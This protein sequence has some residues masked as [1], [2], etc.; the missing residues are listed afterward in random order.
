MRRLLA[1]SAVIIAVSLCYFFVSGQNSLSA[2]PAPRGDGPQVGSL[3]PDFTLTTMK[4]KSVSLAQ[5]RGKVV[6]LNFWASWCP[7]CRAEM[8]SIEKL[9]RR[10]KKKGNFV[11]LAVNVESDARNSIN[12][13][14]RQ[15]PLSFPIL[16]DQD[17]RVSRLYRVSGIPQTFLINPKG[18]IVKKVVGGRDWS[19]PEV[20]AT[21]SS[22]MKEKGE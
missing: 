5:F 1:I 3:A 15:I 7:P 4:G 2:P 21:L 11:L 18:V 6:M 10:M 16:L 17:H 13:F 19:T 8:P 12:E 20:V 9:Y 14:T 22:L